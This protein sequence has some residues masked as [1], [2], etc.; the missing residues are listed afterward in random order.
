MTL[1]GLLFFE[2]QVLLH[3]R[4]C[5]FIGSMSISD[6]NIEALAISGH[7]VVLESVSCRYTWIDQFVEEQETLSV[8]SVSFSSCSWLCR[9][10][11]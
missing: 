5:L 8:F 9:K 4:N 2:G 1:L 7:A 10:S 11:W 6:T 3:W